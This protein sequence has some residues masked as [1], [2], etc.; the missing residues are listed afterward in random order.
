MDGFLPVSTFW[1][2]LAIINAGLAEQKG[3]SR[4]VW[5]LGSLFIGPLATLLIVVMARPDP[6]AEATAEDLRRYQAERAA[7]RSGS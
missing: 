2:T 6:D 7:K 1:F 4:L 3:R 5:F